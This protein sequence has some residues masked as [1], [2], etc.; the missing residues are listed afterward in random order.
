[1]IKYNALHTCFSNF[2]YGKVHLISSIYYVRTL[3]ALQFLIFVLLN[4][5][6]FPW[7]DIPGPTHT[8]LCG[9]GGGAQGPLSVLGGGGGGG[10]TRQWW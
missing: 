9:A 6:T 3:T 4:V 2:S 1:M 7:V 5:K 8:W 10:G